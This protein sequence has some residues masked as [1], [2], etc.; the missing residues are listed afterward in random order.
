[1]PDNTESVRAGAGYIEEGTEF[2]FQFD[3]SKYEL[4]EDQVESPAADESPDTSSP[5]VANE[6]KPDES[7]QDEEKEA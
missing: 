6:V 5:A 2:Y 4:K 7:V 3:C 1:M